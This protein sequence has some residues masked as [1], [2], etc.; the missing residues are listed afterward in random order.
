MKTQTRLRAAV[1]TGVWLGCPARPNPATDEAGASVSFGRERGPGS[2]N[3]HFEGQC[4]KQGRHAGS[5]LHPAPTPVATIT[6]GGLRLPAWIGY[7]RPTLP[8]RPWYGYGYHLSPYIGYY[9]PYYAYR[10]GFAFG[11]KLRV[12][13]ARH[14]RGRDD[15]DC[16]GV[17]AGHS[18]RSTH[19]GSLFVAS[20]GINP[21]GNIATASPGGHLSLRDGGPV[22]P[23]PMPD[24]SRPMPMTRRFHTETS[25]RS[26]ALVHTDQGQEC[27]PG[28][29]RTAAP[30]SRDQ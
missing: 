27:L 26:T 1:L 29:W 15:S 10:P 14:E 9:Q 23:V 8:A 11:L 25:R 4:R 6:V 21:N 22:A 7:Y 13:S 5:Q 12:L 18:F 3:H 24:G 20:G 2:A 28:L 17:G 30:A 19:D 16:R